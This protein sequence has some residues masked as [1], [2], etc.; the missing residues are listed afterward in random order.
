MSNPHVDASSFNCPAGSGSTE[1]AHS[2]VCLAS[3]SEERS[4]SEPCGSAPA[5]MPLFR[6]EVLAERQNQWVGSVVL[7]P[8]ASHRWFTWV[9]AT[10][11]AGLV[12][13]LLLGHFTRTARLGGWL[14]P[15][16]GVARVFAPRP[17][18][19]TAMHVRE[20]APVH[21]GDPLLDLSDELRST[22]LGP[23]QALVMRRLQ[24]R[25][26]SLAQEQLQQRQLLAQQQ[27]GVA[28]RIAALDAEHAQLESEVRLL[29]ERALI[30][31][32][33]EEMHRVQLHQGFI[34]EQRLQLVR[35]ERLEQQARI[36]A[37]ERSRLA[38]RR[39]RLAA[40]AELRDLPLRAQRELGLLDR[41]M[42][43]LDQ[44]RAE[45]E[46]RREIVVTAPQDGHVTSIQ[47]VAGTNADTTVPMLSIVPFQPHLEAHLYGTSRAIGFVRAGQR[48]QL[49]YQ[50]YPYQKFGH[51][52]GLVRSVSQTALGPGELPRE[53]AGLATLAGSPGGL[54]T[55]PIYRITVSLDTPALVSGGASLP[56]QSG[57][58]LEA[59]VALERR[60]LVEW[61]LEPV[62][63]ITGQWQQ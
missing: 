46:A 14:V 57:M 59:D 22:S 3:N 61:L 50:A 24:E 12:A 49:R 33:S 15:Q 29:K 53:L 42:A 41:S 32:R 9:A 55:E 40:E 54:V 11:C 62:F 5:R 26:D 52:V 44:E 60:R 47:A 16:E 19:V 2:Q 45:A 17:G 43:Q 21:K 34:S 25:R 38:N 58:Q 23:T 30:A 8:R 36:A 39:D 31:M 10:T 37:L 63:R 18:V 51:H 35:A 20:G 13:L 28:G 4:L 6:H 7:A 56:L 1:L 27:A 48:V